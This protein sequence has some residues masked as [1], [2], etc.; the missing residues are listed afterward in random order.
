VRRA[1][2]AEWTKLRT[3]G[4]TGWAVFGTIVCTVALGAVVSAATK[5]PSTGCDFDAARVS[6]A[7]VR[8]GQAAAALLAVVAIGGEHTTGM[9]G[10]TLTAMPRRAAVLAAKA[11]VVGGVTL[12]GAAVAVAA[13]VIAGRLLLPHGTAPA[14]GWMLRAAAGS[15]LFLA[16]VALLSL[17]IATAVRDSATATGVVLSLLYA[18][19]LVVVLVANPHWHRRLAQ[20]SPIDA[21]LAIQATTQRSDLPVGPWTGLGVLGAWTVAALICGGILLCRRDA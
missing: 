10:T 19:P 12:A 11:V 14:D 6:L 8:L 1:L 3:L 17:G 20:L 16:L 5:C 15:I 9:I 18:L 13:S 21:G 4:G 2:H 7:G